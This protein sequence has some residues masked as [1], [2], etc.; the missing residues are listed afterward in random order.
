MNRR[1]QKEWFDNER[2]WRETFPFVFSEKLFAIADESVEKALKLANPPGESALDLCCGPGRCSIALASR[3]FSVTGVDRTKYLLDKARSKARAAKVKVHWIQQDMRDFVRPGAFD[4]ILSMF[5]SFGYF[6]NRNDDL[7][8]LANVY[9]SLRPGG[10]FLLDV[11]GKEH[12]AKI[13][14]P[15]LW[16]KLSNGSTLV[17]IRQIVDDWTRVRSEWIVIKKNKALRFTFHI[18]LYS[19]LELRERLE[20]AGFSALKLFGSLDGTP[21]DSEAQRLI[22]VARKQK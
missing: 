18:N 15:A 10:A 19:G 9:R 14:V 4:L 7:R 21:Y 1:R 13:L 22:A 11:N 20:N 8:V 3:G 5:T 6:E 17:D 16:H 2:F 12:L